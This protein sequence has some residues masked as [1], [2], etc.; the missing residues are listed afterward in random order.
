MK[1]SFF[2]LISVLFLPGMNFSAT[3]NSYSGITASEITELI[4]E[5]PGDL[6]PGILTCEYAVNPI[7]IDVA[8]PDLS[9]TVVSGKRKQAQSAYELIV[10]DNIP[11]IANVTGNAWKT[12]KIISS[13]TLHV[14]YSGSPLKSFTRYY[15]RVKVYD[16]DGQSS[17]WSD[18]AW[19]ET[20]MLSEKDWKASW[21]G[22]GKP[23]FTRDEDFYGDDPMPLFRKSFNTGRKVAYARLYI[24]GLGYYEAYINGKKVGDRALDPGWFSYQKQV[25]YSVYDITS[26]LQ[27]GRN[28]CGIMLGNGWYNVLPLRMWGNLNLRQHLAGGRPCLKAELRLN[29]ADGT[30]EVIVTDGSW[31]TAP[32]PVIRNSVYLGEQFDARLEPKNWTIS[33][34][35]SGFMKASVVK[36]PEGKLTVQM[37]P[38]VRITRVIKPVNV[39]QP[40]K[41]VY[42]FDMGQNFAG[43]ARIRV[44]GPA[45][46]RIVL[47]Y[48]ED[49][50]PDGNLNVMTSV[51]GQ[52]KNNNGGPGAPPVAWQEDS[53]ILKGE[54]TETW[55][56]R[57]TFHGFRYV[58]VTGWPGTPSV[59]DI[60]GLRMNSDLGEAGKFHSSNEMFNRL[61]EVAGWTFLS[62]VFSV[63][64][65]CPAREKFGYGGDIVATAEAFIYSFNMAGFYRKAVRDFAEA[66]RPLG[67]ITETAPFVGIADRG[68]GDGSGPLG[69][70]LAYPWLIWQMYDF[71]GDKRIIEENYNFLAEQAAFLKSGS[72]ELLYYSGISDHESLDVKPEAFTSS[73]FWYHHIRLLAAFSEITGRSGRALTYNALADSI[74]IAILNKFHIKGTG[75]FD[76]ASQ[77]AQVFALWYGFPPG[78]ESGAALNALAEELGRHENH[79]STGI[80]ATKMMFDV[81][82][83]TDRNDLAYKVANQRTFPGWGYMLSKGATTLW[84]TWAYSDNV[85]SQN[86][87]MF[88]S[89]TEWFFRSLLGIN[90]GS[91][92]FGKIIIKP[93][94]AGDLTSCNGSYNS[95]RGMIS[96]NWKISNGRILLDVGIPANTTAE[97]WIPSSD[98]DSI[99]AGIKPMKDDKEINILRFENGY[100]IVETGSGNYSFE[101]PCDLF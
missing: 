88:G 57:F 36:G 79:L 42:V 60:E 59:D 71:Y 99:K 53:Y 73:A 58:E 31:L 98:P 9:W 51:A 30:S 78:D 87:P 64:S 54:G 3:F 96:C 101:S 63:Q 93:Q 55:S 67:G 52:I 46:T 56:P 66:R 18:I 47:R 50:Y 32:G 43:V 15:W 6:N 13:Q 39:S 77:A 82:R 4:T 10:S 70:Q 92:G 20:A 83:K 68:P 80:F 44:K 97:I 37:Q 38:P 90:Q 62:N 26:L 22:D 41:D 40:K 100:C 27:D 14:R 85:Y 25:P 94:P 19:F 7:G 61:F 21:I 33:E 2:L 72:K 8:D 17:P 45:G 84:E 81:L 12:G 86:H 65:D 35:S 48:G 24:S 23:Q 95:I 28:V 29:Y 76:S 11:D 69:W 16:K 74:R 1:K 91:P 75:R 5:D 89:V 34:R 49:I